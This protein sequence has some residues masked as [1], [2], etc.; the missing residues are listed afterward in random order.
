MKKLIALLLILC[1]LL[2]CGCGGG[3]NA[4]DDIIKPSNDDKVTTL[5]DANGQVYDVYRITT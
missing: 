5:E 1:M 2:A 4:E 3:K